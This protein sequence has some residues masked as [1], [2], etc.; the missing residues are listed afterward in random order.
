MKLKKFYKDDLTAAQLTSIDA[1]YA[2]HL[3]DMRAAVS[4]N[5]WSA[6]QQKVQKQMIIPLLAKY[7]TLIYLGIPREKAM[8]LTEKYSVHSA[9]R[10]NKMLRL[11]S[12]LPNFR[13]LFSKIFK[14]QMAV[15]GIWDHEFK[16]DDKEMM[17]FDV[18]KCLW[19]ETCN[20]FGYPEICEIFCNNDWVVFGDIK[21]FHLERV[22]TLG[23]GDE[24]CDFKFVFDEQ[25]K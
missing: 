3:S 8:A 2:K 11:F 14:K 7:R 16:K 22:G 13:K 4:N 19:K 6:E 9:R 18:T 23:L 25:K 15:P 12:H 10:F 5:N 24:K 21:K 20:F 1:E 17:V